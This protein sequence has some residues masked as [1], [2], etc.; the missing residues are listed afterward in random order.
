MSEKSGA[1]FAFLSTHPT[2]KKRVEELQRLIEKKG[3][4]IG[5]RSPLPKTLQ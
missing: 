3:Y 2:P 1:N 5:T 4:E